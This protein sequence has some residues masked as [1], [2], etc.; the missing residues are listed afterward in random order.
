[1][2]A[3]RHLL[4]K[5]DT[6]TEEAART[7]LSD[8]EKFLKWY[9]THLTA[10]NADDRINIQD[11]F[12]IQ[13]IAEATRVTLPVYTRLSSG[14]RRLVLYNTEAIDV[15]CAITTTEVPLLRTATFSPTK[16]H[17]AFAYDDDIQPPDHTLLAKQKELSLN[18]ELEYC[19]GGKIYLQ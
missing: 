14:L 19:S 5:N 9:M 4:I 2:C 17:S 1:M 10:P 11:D 16:L 15:V 6:W 18:L 7:V 8:D 12:E 3:I 13:A